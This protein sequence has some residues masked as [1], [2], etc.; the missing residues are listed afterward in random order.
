M[1][2]TVD[3]ATTI[4]IRVAIVFL[5][6]WFLFIIRDVIWLFLIAIIIT[7]ALNPII[8]R[9]Q[10]ILKSKRGVSVGVVYILFFTLI[11][12]LIAII[13][14]LLS[15]QFNQLGKELPQFIA[16]V[17]PEGMEIPQE[18]SFGDVGQKFVELVNNPFSTTVGFF[19]TVISVAA[20]ISMSFYMSLQKDGLKRALLII[21]PTQYKSYI[22][23]L[24]DRIQENFGRWMVG[25]VI[26]MVFVGVLYY[27]A[28]ILLGV[29]YAP[30]LALIGG[31]L[32]IIPYFGP[33]IA[34]VPAI[35]FGLMIDPMVGIMVAVAYFV[36]NLIENHFL[37]P[38][39]MNK[40]IGLNPVLI[41]LA[42]LIGGKIAGVIGIF[43]AVPIAGAIGLFVRDMMD[44]RVSS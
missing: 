32:E 11:T 40:A 17:V 13:A 34:S 43:L 30:V 23:S 22:A 31:L 18:I 3:T 41:I 27:V 10:K 16:Q 2:S 39:I 20:V 29:P 12:L 36:I 19:S 33:I 8:I 21:T 1:N 14:P 35:L 5:V 6:L 42:L 7:A 38:K 25:Q 26:T 24:V 15:E 28:L 4:I 44:K 37:I 9:T